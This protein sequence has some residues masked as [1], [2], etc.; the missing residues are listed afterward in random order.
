[1]TEA[2][3]PGINEAEFLKQAEAAKDNC[4]VSKALAD[5]QISLSAKLV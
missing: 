5:P 2:E 1:M 4:P 3:V